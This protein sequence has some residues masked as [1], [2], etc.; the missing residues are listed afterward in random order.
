MKFFIIRLDGMFRHTLVVSIVLSRGALS[1]C[2]GGGGI[3]THGGFHHAGF[4]DRSV[5]TA[6]VPLRVNYSLYF[7]VLCFLIMLA[8]YPTLYPDVIKALILTDPRSAHL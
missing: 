5:I 8:L 7:N 1:L 6:S 3:R 2:G 4:Q